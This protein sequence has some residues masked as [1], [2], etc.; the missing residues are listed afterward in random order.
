M[1]GILFPMSKTVRLQVFKKEICG[2]APFE[3]KTKIFTFG[4]YTK[5]SINI[6]KI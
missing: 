3:N 2:L 6:L 4:A 5:L 1:F